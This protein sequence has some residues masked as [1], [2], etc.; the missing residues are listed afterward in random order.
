MHLVWTC[1][2][3]RI[4]HAFLWGWMRQHIKYVASCWFDWFLLA[5][6]SLPNFLTTEFLQMQSTL[7]HQEGRWMQVKLHPPWSKV[8]HCQCNV[9]AQ[10]CVER[11]V[12][13]SSCFTELPVELIEAI[14]ESSCTT[15]T[16][17]CL[18][19]CDLGISWDVVG[20]C[21]VLGC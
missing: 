17:I 5:V 13:V 1:P 19:E 18:M 16:I 3:C 6:W 8:M 12:W 21:W 11:F 10:K 4:V 9:V 2:A 7:A 20:C 15:H 14:L